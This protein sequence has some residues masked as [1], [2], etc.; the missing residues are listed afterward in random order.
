MQVGGVAVCRVATTLCGKIYVRMWS[1]KLRGAR[2][3]EQAAPTQVVQ[4]G[5]RDSVECAAVSGSARGEGKLGRGRSG[6]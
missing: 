6:E 4:C 5:G 1:D 2:Q 3:M